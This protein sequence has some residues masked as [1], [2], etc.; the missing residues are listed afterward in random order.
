MALVTEW[1]GKLQGVYNV[2]D[3]LGDRVGRQ[4]ARCV[5]C[6]S[7]YVVVLSGN[8]KQYFISKCYQRCVAVKRFPSQCLCVLVYTSISVFASESENSEFFHVMERGPT[9]I[10]GRLMFVHSVPPTR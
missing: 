5:Q 4:V 3:G 8:Y 6:S 10:L 2:T 1:E 7:V 9:E